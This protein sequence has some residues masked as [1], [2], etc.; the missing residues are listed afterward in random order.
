[1]KLSITAPELSIIIDH[2][3]GVKLS[4]TAPELSINHHHPAG[5]WGWGH[6][7]GGLGGLDGGGGPPSGLWAP[8]GDPLGATSPP[9]PILVGYGIPWVVFSQWALGPHG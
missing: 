4:I 5:I 8:M 9:P 6:P 1:M 2:P 7:S 3:A